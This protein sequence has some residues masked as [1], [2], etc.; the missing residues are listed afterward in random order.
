MADVS[1]L[2]TEKYFLLSMIIFFIV[3]FTFLP[4]QVSGQWTFNV[5]IL[6]D[7]C[8][9]GNGYYK[10]KSY[11]FASKTVN[12]LS[13]CVSVISGLFFGVWCS[14]GVHI[15]Q[16]VSMWPVF[17][18]TLLSL[19]MIYE[20]VVHQDFSTGTG[21]GSWFGRAESFHNNPFWFMF[22]MLLKSGGIYIGIR[23]PLTA[24]VASWRENKT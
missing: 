6:L 22:F 14:K 9:F 8:L 12:S 1:R 15:K 17:L 7:K 2:K 4:S 3:L 19:Y 21:R 23:F 20:S 11:L 16:N 10:P 24:A 5:D 18:L 13:V